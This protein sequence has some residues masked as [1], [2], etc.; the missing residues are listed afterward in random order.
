M[1]PASL[2]PTACHVCNRA[3]LAHR[4]LELPVCRFCHGQAAVVPGECYRS[5]DVRL[6]E[7]IERAVFLSQLSEQSSYRL[8]VVL[9]NVSERWRCPD[10]L[11]VP[12][13]AAVPSL[14]FLF[15]DF[16]TDRT[17]LSQAVG[18]ILA[19]VTTQLRTFE[20]A[21]RSP[22]ITPSSLPEQRPE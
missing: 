16:G 15:D 12:V 20:A 4:T 14:Q 19:A 7:D 11:L 6:F 17:Q 21:R 5:D 22:A 10:A 8:W 18:M 1:A 2:V 13:V 9:S 3:W